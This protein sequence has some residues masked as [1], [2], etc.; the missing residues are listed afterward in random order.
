MADKMEG[1]IYHVF[2]FSGIISNNY[3][4]VI[5]LDMCN[6]RETIKQLFGCW[7]FLQQPAVAAA[8]PSKQQPIEQIGAPNSHGVNR[9]MNKSRLKMGS[10][11]CLSVLTCMPRKDRSFLLHA[12]GPII[13]RRDFRTGS[14]EGDKDHGVCRSAHAW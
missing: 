3:M 11:A 6:Q 12:H 7:P 5:R 1:H 4:H 14:M 13:N 10:V 8:Q 9:E 2:G